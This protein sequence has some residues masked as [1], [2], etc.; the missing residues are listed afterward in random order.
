M[1]VQMECL[2]MPPSG[3]VVRTYSLQSQFETP[4]VLELV[5]THAR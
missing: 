2:F 5:A 3:L 4:F 1:V